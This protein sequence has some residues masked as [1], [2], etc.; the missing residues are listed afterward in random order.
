MLD[1]RRREGW[2]AVMSLSSRCCSGHVRMKGGGRLRQRMATSETT[3]RRPC[4]KSVWAIVRLRPATLEYSRIPICTRNLCLKFLAPCLMPPMVQ[5]QR[6]RWYILRVA[7]HTVR[8]EVGV[9]AR[10]ARRDG[11]PSDVGLA[12]CC[13]LQAGSR[14][15]AG[16]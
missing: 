6:M 16:V 10:A 4:A 7:L 15:G 13:A 9:L 2:W 8:Q 1:S 3:I 5:L 14:V 11:H 12:E